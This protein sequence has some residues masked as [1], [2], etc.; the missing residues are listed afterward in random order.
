[1]PDR[2][3]HGFRTKATPH[4]SQAKNTDTDVSRTD[5]KC[6]KYGFYDNGAK[7]NEAQKIRPE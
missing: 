5:R 1:M 4:L 7:W 3:K 6:R 2:L